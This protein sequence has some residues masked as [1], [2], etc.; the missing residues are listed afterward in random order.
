M[1]LS[2][3]AL[4][5]LSAAVWKMFQYCV[6]EPLHQEGMAFRN[7]FATLWLPWRILPFKT[8][9]LQIK[10]LSLISMSMKLCLGY[11][12]QVSHSTEVK[13]N[14]SGLTQECSP[15]TYQPYL[16]C[17]SSHCRD[18]AN[19]PTLLLVQLKPCPKDR[20]DNY[21]LNSSF[22]NE[23]TYFSFM[24]SPLLALWFTRP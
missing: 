13:V 7:V 4:H 9:W 15:D 24:C 22:L 19:T 14:R 11:C 21:F 3:I 1:L 2:G 17:R 12:N 20:W 6:T 18:Y 10:D 5:F 23:I 8:T 16:H